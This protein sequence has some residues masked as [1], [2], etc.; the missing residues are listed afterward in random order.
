LRAYA[1]ERKDR[2]TWYKYLP[3]VQCL[4]NASTHK[5]IGV[6]P[7]QII[8]YNAVQLDRQLLPLAESTSSSTRKTYKEHLEDMLNAQSKI[9]KLAN[10]T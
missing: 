1:Y 9:L 3:L 2:K 8:V 7:A 10:K 4:L 6:S 5:S